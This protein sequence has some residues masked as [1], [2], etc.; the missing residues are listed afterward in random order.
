LIEKNEI[1]DPPLLLSLHLETISE[2]KQLD[3]TG[4][5][6]DTENPVAP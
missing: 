1:E 5:D 6:S 4:V 3:C 2:E